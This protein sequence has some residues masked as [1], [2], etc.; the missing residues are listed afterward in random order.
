MSSCAYVEMG[1]L[2]CE[3]VGLVCIHGKATCHEGLVS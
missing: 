3:L 1:M 2:R